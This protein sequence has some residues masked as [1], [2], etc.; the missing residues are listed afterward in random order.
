M[1]NGVALSGG[2]IGGICAYAALQTLA[3]NQFRFD[4][5]S[6]SSLPALSA[7]LYCCGTPFKQCY[8]LLKTMFC[9]M[10]DLNITCYIENLIQIGEHARKVAQ[11]QIPLHLCFTDLANGGIVLFSDTLPSMRGLITTYPLYGHSY[12]ALFASTVGY[13]GM[14]PYRFGPHLLYDF[15]LRGG[16]PILPLRM[17]GIKRVIAM[18]FL[19]SGD[20]SPYQSAAD[21]LIALSSNTSDFYLPIL[22][23]DPSILP[24]A[25]YDTYCSVVREALETSMQDDDCFLKYGYEC[26]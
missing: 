21:R 15:A 23:P 10:N 3:E 22:P 11:T 9:C 14:E 26:G 7:Y 12:D 5:V 18:A 6:C 4:A 25:R 16:L 24:P 1:S 8:G 19:S 13:F 17:E 2:D 20:Y